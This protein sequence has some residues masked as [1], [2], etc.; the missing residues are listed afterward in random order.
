[1]P[2]QIDESQIKVGDLAR[3]LPDAVLPEIAKNLLADIMQSIP[4][5]HMNGGE[6]LYTRGFVDI[7]GGDNF[8]NVEVDVPLALGKEIVRDSISYDLSGE[9]EVQIQTLGVDNNAVL[10]QIGLFILSNVN[11]GSHLHNFAIDLLGELGAVAFYKNQGTV[12]AGEVE[13][14]MF[15]AIDKSIKKAVDIKTKYFWQGV[16]KHIEALLKFGK[17][18]LF[19]S[20]MDVFNDAVGEDSNARLSYDIE[21]DFAGDV[22]VVEEVLNYIINPIEYLKANP[23]MTINLTQ[24]EQ[25]Y[26]KLPRQPGLPGIE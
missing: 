26:G 2:E 25:Q 24:Y 23:D 14:Y 6:S 10:D 11:S 12:E 13:G 1:M 4:P 8:F 3:I 17:I 7:M 15:E 20:A 9:Q 5:H 21:H 19:K 22:E 18:E 16:R